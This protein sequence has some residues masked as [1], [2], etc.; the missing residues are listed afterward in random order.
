MNNLITQL[1]NLRRIEPDALFIERSRMLI[2]GNLIEARPIQRSSFFTGWVPAFAFGGVF[3]AVVGGIIFLL[4]EPRLHAARGLN[5]RELG[6]EL[7]T[8]TI[9]LEAITYRDAVGR[10]IAAALSPD[11][12]ASFLDQAL[13]EKGGQN[14]V[15]KQI[16]ALLK[17]N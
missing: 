10:A 3:I 8:I 9:E 7:G 11:D 15:N 12:T 1:K 14:A 6:T 13:L 17:A 5:S 16:D 4:G 2:V